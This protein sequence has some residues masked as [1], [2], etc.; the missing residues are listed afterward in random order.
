MRRLL[1][2]LLDWIYP[3]RAVCMG[4]GTTAGFSGEWLCDDCRRRLARSQLGA[5]MDPKLDG[6]A[7]AY[8]YNGPAGSI[9]R[10]MKFGGIT[11]L[12]GFMAD[13]MAEVYPRIQPTGAELVAAVPMH[14]KRLRRRGFNHSELLARA[15]ADR[16]GLPFE[17]ALVRT[18]NTVQ[19]A[20]LSGE[21]R[22]HNLTDAFRAD[23]SVA[24]KRVLLVD[25]VYTT[26]E[27]ARECAKA[28]RAAGAKNVYLLAFAM[29]GG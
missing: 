17:N 23:P 9:V 22:L 18:R 19:Q 10:K 11:G 7:V 5:R 25:D 3:R 20:S 13:A 12:T 24:G 27:T 1:D 21:A 16:L 4:C 26:G 6:M 15:V 14:P 8:P 2:G 29:G 28:L